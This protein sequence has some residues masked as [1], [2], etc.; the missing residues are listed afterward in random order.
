MYSW[1]TRLFIVPA[2]MMVLS[3]EK[4]IALSSE[5]SVCVCVCVCVCERRKIKT[6]P[7]PPLVSAAA[8]FSSV[9]SEMETCPSD[10]ALL[11]PCMPLYLAAYT[12]HARSPIYG[13]KSQHVRL[14]DILVKWHLTASLMLSDAEKGAVKKYYSKKMPSKKVLL[15]SCPLH[16]VIRRT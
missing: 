10:S 9:Y 14:R 15:I 3:K 6:R 11:L 2:K 13:G 16:S 7:R 5:K 1:K 12:W 8:W 4:S